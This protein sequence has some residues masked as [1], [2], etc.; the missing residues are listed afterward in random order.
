[1][2]RSSNLGFKDYIGRCGGLRKFLLPALVGLVLL[3][4]G[5]FGGIGGGAGTPDE[6]ERLAALCSSVDGVGECRAVITY[7]RSGEVSGVALICEGADSVR[8]RA[9]LV[10][11]VRSLYGVGANSVFIESG[12]KN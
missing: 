1:M 11:L 7:S 5:I 12:R 9:R 10:S 4:I 3:A 8:V 2:S 6:E